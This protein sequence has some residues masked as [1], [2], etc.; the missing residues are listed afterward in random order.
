MREMAEKAEERARKLEAEGSPDA[1]FARNRAE[2]LKAKAIKAF[3]DLPPGTT[4]LPPPPLRPNSV[5]ADPASAAPKS[6]GGKRAAKF[7][8]RKALSEAERGPLAADAGALAAEIAVSAVRPGFLQVAASPAEPLTPDEFESARLIVESVTDENAGCPALTEGAADPVRW[9]A[10]TFPVLPPDTRVRCAR[11]LSAMAS[12]AAEPPCE[13]AEHGIT[14][15]ERALEHSGMSYM[16]F[17][18]ARRREIR[19]ADAEAAVTAARERFLMNRMD[20][21]LHAR[22]LYGQDEEM[23]DRMGTPVRV[24][25]YDNGL[26]FNILKVR[27]ENYGKQMLKDKAAANA[28]TLMIA[29]G[30]MPPNE[31][32]PRSPVI[33][34]IPVMP[35]MAEVIEHGQ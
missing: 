7:V 27:H 26:A 3:A 10:E 30:V 14:V 32:V 5:R 28:M 15:A 34:V 20:E 22:A 8:G 12:M 4:H 21:V 1:P 13:D 9:L 29:N 35:K 31:T 11:F 17:D 23:L 16:A 19:F 33:P 6:F 2:V 25:R 24:H 18:A